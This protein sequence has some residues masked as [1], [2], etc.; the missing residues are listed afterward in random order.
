MS[1]DTM[2]GEML[3]QCELEA[4][5]QGIADERRRMIDALE[6]GCGD[7]S[8][9][10][11]KPHGMATNGGCQCVKSM[12]FQDRRDFLHALNTVRAESVLAGKDCGVAEERA[13]WEGRLERLRELHGHVGSAAAKRVVV[14]AIAIM[15]RDEE[16]PKP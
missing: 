16:E 3:D 11:H 15:E 12:P 2:A 9:V 10:L 6:R 5:R 7:N 13:R 14:L 1:Y 8:C 4:Y